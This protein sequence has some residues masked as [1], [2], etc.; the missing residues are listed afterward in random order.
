MY[1][2]VVGKDGNDTSPHSLVA[3]STYSFLLDHDSAIPAV[4]STWG[5]VAEEEVSL[6]ASYFALP[7]SRYNACFVHDRIC[8][9]DATAEIGFQFSDWESG[10]DYV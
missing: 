3:Y 7:Q 5:S 4:V 9:S 1:N 2:F 10:G 6:R 8:S